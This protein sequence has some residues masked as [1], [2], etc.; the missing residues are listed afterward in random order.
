[1]LCV[2]KVAVLDDRADEQGEEELEHYLEHY[3]AL[4]ARRSNKN[5]LRNLPPDELIQIDVPK[6]FLITT[7][8]SLLSRES[9]TCALSYVLDGIGFYYY[10]LL[11]TIIAP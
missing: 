4:L 7:D 8:A 3:A 5:V 6:Y 10:W 1:V 2:V 9:F 11:V